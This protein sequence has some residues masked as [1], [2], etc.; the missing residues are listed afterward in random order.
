MSCPL[1]IFYRSWNTT[2]AIAIVLTASLLSAGCETIKRGADA[3]RT[4]EPTVGKPA[5][6][7]P[8]NLAGYSAAFKEGYA[9][10]CAT[11]RRS[12]AARLKS[13]TDYSMGWTDGSTACKAR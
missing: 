1:P 10:A 2:G 5:P 13:D 8:Y 3:P 7:A 12:N 11:P 4:S 6:P 9:D